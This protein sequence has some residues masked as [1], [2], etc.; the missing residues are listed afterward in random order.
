MSY[1]ATPQLIIH[2]IQVTDSIHLSDDARGHIERLY[3]QG[4]QRETKVLYD[5]KEHWRMK[6]LSK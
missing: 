1:L 2:M 4:I 6:Y 5:N 3:M